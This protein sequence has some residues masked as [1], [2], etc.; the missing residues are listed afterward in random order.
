[1]LG[2]YNIPKEP[3]KPKRPNQPDEDAMADEM[4]EY[5]QLT[6]DY[7]AQMAKYET[8]RLA[9]KCKEQMLTWYLDEWLPTVAGIIGRGDFAPAS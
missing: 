3:V 1:M 8:L 5:N 7:K 9:K 6:Q 2:V 4:A